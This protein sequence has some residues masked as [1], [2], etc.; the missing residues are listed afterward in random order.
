MAMTPHKVYSVNQSGGGGITP[1]ALGLLDGFT[2]RLVSGPCTITR[3]I[4]DFEIFEGTNSTAN[5]YDPVNLFNPWQYI[6]ALTEFASGTGPGGG[7]ILSPLFDPA[8]DIL[9]AGLLRHF[10]RSAANLGTMVPETNPIEIEVQRKIAAGQDAV[11]WV[12]FQNENAQTSCAGYM[13]LW[14]CTIYLT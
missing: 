13:N 12:A 4:L 14:G 10:L 2:G 11:I 3:V 1:Q 8:N 9:H 5:F 7:P 6:V